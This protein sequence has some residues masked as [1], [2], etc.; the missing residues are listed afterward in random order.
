[1]LLLVLAMYVLTT[2]CVLCCVVPGS[3]FGFCLLVDVENWNSCAAAGR[4]DTNSNALM[5]ADVLPLWKALGSNELALVSNGACNNYSNTHTR[6]ST[7][8]S[9]GL[10]AT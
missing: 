6:H 10:L 1:M 7:L 2:V 4:R 9:V 8:R 5:A 3:P